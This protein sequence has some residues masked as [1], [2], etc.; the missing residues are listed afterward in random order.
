MSR[1]VTREDIDRLVQA[2]ERLSLAFEQ[3]A[4]ATSSSSTSVTVPIISQAGWE[5]VEPS[6]VVP[7]TVPKSITG[8]EEGV[9]TIPH[10]LLVSASSKI[11]SVVG[12]PQERVHRAWK[13]GFAAWVAVSTHTEYTPVEPLPSLSDTI[14]VIL[15]APSLNGAVRVRRVSELRSLLAVLPSG[16]CG[17]VHQ[18][19]PSLT[20]VQVFCAAAGI[21]TPPVFQCRSHK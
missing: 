1:P 21:D 15:R 13:A 20:E 16:D 8:V 10:S 12:Q 11:S 6:V 14:W 3:A 18:G 19:F 17:P 9:P 4:A 5:L 7:W 2:V